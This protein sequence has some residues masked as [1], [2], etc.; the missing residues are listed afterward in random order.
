MR[1]VLTQCLLLSSLAIR[2][3]AQEAVRP[4]RFEIVVASS[5]RSTPLTGR[6]VLVVSKN[7]EPEP[8]L[9]VA[10]QGPAIFG[11]DLE[12][13]RP[14]AAAIVDTTSLGYPM[15][16]AALPTGDYFVQPVINVY[17]QVHRADGK[18]IW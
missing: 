5:A 13:L 1:T 3:G 11:V 12:Q 9:T 6:L 15:K 4:P 10:P 8:R 14:G 2:A 7:A 18:T 17:E 16:L